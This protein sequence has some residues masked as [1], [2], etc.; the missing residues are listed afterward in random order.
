MTKQLSIRFAVSLLI[1]LVVTSSGWAGK[2]RRRTP[3][4]DP[5]A[6][7]AQ[8]LNL[9]N[10]NRA[11]DGEKPLAINPRLMSAAQD[12]AEYLA[13]TGKFSHTAEGTP[14]QRE[15]ESGY[16]HHASGE[17]IA[18]GQT[19]AAAVVKGWMNSEGHRKNILSKNFNEVGFGVA[20]GKNGRIYWV[21]DFGHK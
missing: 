10:L 3:N 18:V 14:G 16:K 6:T 12:Y 15:S 17:N 20:K 7:V 2:G 11:Q 5:D 1:L 9:H 8:L 21:T 4:L 13:R 19:S